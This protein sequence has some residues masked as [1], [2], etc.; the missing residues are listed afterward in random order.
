MHANATVLMHCISEIKLRSLGIKRGYFA[1]LFSFIEVRMSNIVIDYGN[2][3]CHSV[4]LW[5][6]MLSTALLV[7]TRIFSYG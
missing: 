7:W 2:F 5:T 6:G 3:E 4:I 1:C